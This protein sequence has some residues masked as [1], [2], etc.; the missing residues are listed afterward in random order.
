MQKE[1]AAEAKV[2]EYT[3]LRAEKGVSLRVDSA[4]KIAEA[5][6]V[7]VADLQESPPVPLGEA[8][9]DPP[10]EEA[11]SPLEVSEAE[12]G[13]RRPYPYPW[14]TDTLTETI[15]RWSKASLEQD[16]PKYSHIVAVAC[17]DV[18]G[19]ILKYGVPGKTLRDRVPENEV[20][21]RL[22][23]V[24]WLYEVARRAQEHYADS[25]AA[26]AAEVRGLEERSDNVLRLM[27]ET[28]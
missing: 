11:P 7:S 1:L 22:N 3:V 4:R 6:G 17:F 27:K 20:E 15:A 16:D 9:G 21:E 23:L 18:M 13:E 28:A 25:E 26:S 10:K 24:D 14:M 2:S 8:P 5:L 19:S 12:D